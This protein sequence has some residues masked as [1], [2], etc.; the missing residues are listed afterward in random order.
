MSWVGRSLIS[1]ILSYLKP[2]HNLTMSSVTLVTQE[3]YLLLCLLLSGI[4]NGNPDC[5]P[6]GVPWGV[7]VLQLTCT[8]F[9]NLGNCV[10]NRIWIYCSRHLAL[11]TWMQNWASALSAFSCC[12]CQ[13]QMTRKMR[14]FYLFA[15]SPSNGEQGLTPDYSP[16]RTNSIIGSSLKWPQLI[17]YPLNILY[18]IT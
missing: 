15:S 1:M 8:P 16:F 13:T 11:W 7:N 2:L 12:S 4:Q 5:N 9:C 14:R 18:E 3:Y 17:L 10:N 6:R